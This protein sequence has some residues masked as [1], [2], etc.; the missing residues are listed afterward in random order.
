MSASISES[1][2]YNTIGFIRKDPYNMSC[3]ENRK[4]IARVMP[5]QPLAL[6]RRE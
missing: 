3:R 5:T 4:M 2:K 6:W 1:G